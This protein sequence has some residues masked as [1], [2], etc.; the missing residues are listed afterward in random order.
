MA[1]VLPACLLLALLLL[2]PAQS[3][4]QERG[5]IINLVRGDRPCPRHRMLPLL[6]GTYM[7]GLEA[8]AGFS[9]VVR[10]LGAWEIS[11]IRG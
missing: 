3:A 10:E 5:L 6:Q 2:A 4:E 7:D 8:S 1:K 9:G 11:S